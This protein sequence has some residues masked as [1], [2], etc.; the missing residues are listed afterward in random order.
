[1]RPLLLAALLLLSLPALAAPPQPLDQPGW[2]ALRSAH[3]GQPTIVHFWGLSCGPCL[4]E[5][6]EWGALLRQRPGLDLIVVE[7]DQVE[8]R[9]DRI[10]AVL[11]KAGLGQAKSRTLADPFDDRLRYRIDAGWA[12]ELPL[13]LLIGRDGTVTRVLGGADFAAVRRWLNQ[14]TEQHR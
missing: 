14:Q 3:A 8:A 13:T 4:V 6:P 12:G 11:D 5:L 9:P 2:A 7:A 1:M 10:A